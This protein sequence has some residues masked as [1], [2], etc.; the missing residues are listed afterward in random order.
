MLASE[1]MVKMHDV[2]F[3]RAPQAMAA[4]AEDGTLDNWDKHVLRVLDRAKPLAQIA[5][6][7][8]SA[9][10]ES[11]IK[12]LM[13]RGLVMEVPHEFSPLAKTATVVDGESNAKVNP[14]REV[15]FQ[16]ARRRVSKLI[17]ERMG[18]SGDHMSLAI[19]RTGNPDDLLQTVQRLKPVLNGADGGRWYSTIEAECRS[20]QTA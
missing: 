16:A 1:V 2:A 18:P 12:K 9:V 13:A 14:R 4:L 3:I 17:T 7:L 15:A 5:R 8:P 19:E 6:G 10:F 20:L 11:S